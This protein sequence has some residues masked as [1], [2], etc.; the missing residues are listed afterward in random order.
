MR[1]DQTNVSREAKGAQLTGL[2]ALGLSVHS[3]LAITQE[4]R[5]N[6]G[7]LSNY[8]CLIRHVDVRVPAKIIYYTI[9]RYIHVAKGITVS[10]VEGISVRLFRLCAFPP[11][12]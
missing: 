10:S 11:P 12:A 4:V 2:P 7:S 1:Y 9:T 8:E 5:R 6:R 3:R